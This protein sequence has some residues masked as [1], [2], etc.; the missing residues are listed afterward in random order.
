MHKEEDAAPH[1]RH[2]IAQCTHRKTAS[3]KQTYTPPAVNHQWK[4]RRD[5]APPPPVQSHGQQDI[6]KA[7]S[8]YKT[9]TEQAITQRATRRSDSLSIH[10]AAIKFPEISPTMGFGARLKAVI[11][12]ASRL[13]ESDS[14]CEL[15]LSSPRSMPTEGGGGHQHATKEASKSTA[16]CILCG[17]VFACRN[18]RQISKK[19]EQ[20]M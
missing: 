3:T 20:S 18:T 11:G 10:E 5:T 8:Q 12:G 2:T 17:C 16:M 15:P 13:Q 14:P 9:H 1:S 6:A 19:E 4:M 7:R